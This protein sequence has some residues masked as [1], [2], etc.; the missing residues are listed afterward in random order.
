[1]KNNRAKERAF[2][3][4]VEDD[5]LAEAEAEAADALAEERAYKHEGVDP[6]IWF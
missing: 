3:K 1:M 2:Y 5:A 6:T 4:Q